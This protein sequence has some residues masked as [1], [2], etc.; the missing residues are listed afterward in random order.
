M[1]FAKLTKLVVSC[2][3]FPFSQPDQPEKAHNK[4]NPS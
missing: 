2:Y 4:A 3:Y 1:S